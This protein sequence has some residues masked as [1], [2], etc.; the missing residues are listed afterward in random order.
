MRKANGVTFKY[1]HMT[2]TS[3]RR[4]FATGIAMGL[5]PVQKGFA[6]G[7]MSE[8][9]KP[10]RYKHT[11][12]RALNVNRSRFQHAE[13]SLESFSDGIG[14]NSEMDK[15][16]SWLYINAHVGRDSL[17]SNLASLMPAQ[18][19]G[20]ELNLKFHMDF[21]NDIEIKR[22]S[23]N[24]G[25]E[26]R[27]SPAPDALPVGQFIL[28]PTI[29]H[30]AITDAIELEPDADDIYRYRVRYSTESVEQ[31]GQALRDDSLETRLILDILEID[32]G[33]P[34]LRGR[35]DAGQISVNN[36]IV[37]SLRSRSASAFRTADESVSE[38]EPPPGGCFITTA[39]CDT[40]GFHDRCWELQSLRRFRDR[41][42][43]RNSNNRAIVNEYYRIAPAL[44]KALVDHT[45]ASRVCARLYLFYIMPMAAL[46][47]CRLDGLIP[48]YYHRLV[49]RVQL[50][51]VDRTRSKP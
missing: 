24:W 50:V 10:K 45:D 34:R 3:R 40:M 48:R 51:T 9:A 23:I 39:V 12:T 1:T 29:V 14:A 8:D 21:T 30:D 43:C 44:T 4:F 28:R 7:D 35:I 31:L 32:D 2:I 49:R 5:V 19:E 42:G 27:I 26:V 20:I 25:P 22:T 16:D 18:V 6:Q 15:D 41:W 17:P 46:A 38:V 36:T 47:T 37:A 11:S 33:E 13:V